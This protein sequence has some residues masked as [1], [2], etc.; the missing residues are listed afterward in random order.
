MT[1]ALSPL[2]AAL[3]AKPLDARLDQ[4]EP[5]V[6]ERI[7]REQSQAQ[8]GLWRWRAGVAA[9]MLASGTLAGGAA[10]ANAVAD[11]SPFAVHSAYAPSTLLESG[12]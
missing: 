7:G 8:G 5:R 10:A 12:R 1:D 3:R 9:A 11:P 2:L 4:L 6:W